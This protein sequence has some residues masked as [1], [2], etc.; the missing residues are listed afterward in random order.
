MIS[1]RQLGAEKP[2]WFAVIDGMHRVTSLQEL[3]DEKWQGIE[4]DQVRTPHPLPFDSTHLILPMAD[5]G[6]C[7]RGTYSC[8]YHPVDRTKSIHLLTSTCCCFVLIPVTSTLQY[9]GS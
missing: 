3:H 7:V 8:K 1:V 4:Y 9:N 6:D 2:G 5:L